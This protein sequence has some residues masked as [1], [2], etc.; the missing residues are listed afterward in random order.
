MQIPLAQEHQHQLQ[1]QDQLGPAKAPAA[2][3]GVL[4]FATCRG[5]AH[6]AA[7]ANSAACPAALL[8]CCTAAE[9]F[10]YMH[11]TVFVHPP[12]AVEASAKPMYFHCLLC[13][14]CA[15]GAQKP[16]HI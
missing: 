14:V 9:A 2:Q 7:I 5:P 1:K 11:P 10:M 6:F 3:G 16:S 13:C 8:F 4:A 12:E 15:D